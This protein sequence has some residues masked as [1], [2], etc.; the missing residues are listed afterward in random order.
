GLRAMLG[1][2][3]P[4]FSIDELL[5]QNKIVLLSLNRGR[6]GSEAARL[7]GSL[8][9]SHLWTRILARQ[10]LPAH[11]RKIVTVYIDEVH[12][13]L[14]GIPRRPSRCSGTG[15]LTRRRLRSGEPVSRSTVPRHADSDR[16]QHHVQDLLRNRRA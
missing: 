5:S 9:M 12:D 13:I 10:A 16:R 1:Q 3:N 2:T 7:L 15:P 6:V 4:K 11:K 14:S 8:V